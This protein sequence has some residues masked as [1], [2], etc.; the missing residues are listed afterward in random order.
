M[1][2]GPMYV[3]ASEREREDENGSANER[4]NAGVYV[5]IVHVEANLEIVADFRVGVLGHEHLDEGRIFRC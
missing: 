1:S 4:G 5:D 2:T 3:Y